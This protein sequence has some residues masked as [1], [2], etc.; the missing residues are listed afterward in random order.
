MINT[1]KI[2][3]KIVPKIAIDSLDYGVMYRYPKSGNAQDVYMK[4]D[5]GGSVLLATGRFFN[6]INLDVDVEVID[7]VTISR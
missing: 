3:D 1:I 7:A 5:G 4:T 2:T 6:A